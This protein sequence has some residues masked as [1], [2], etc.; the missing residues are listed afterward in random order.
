MLKKQLNFYHN[1]SWLSA[2]MLALTLNAQ[3][4]TPPFPYQNPDLSPEDRA[5]D[6]VARMTLAEKVSQMQNSAV[7]IPRIGIPDY[8]W[9]N[10]ALHGVAR[11]P[12]SQ[13]RSH[14]RSAL[15]PRGTRI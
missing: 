13:L 15:P 9:W 1:M 11:A 5:A 3:D 7:A 2:I 4:G 10:E 8:D 6:L 12:A 14:R